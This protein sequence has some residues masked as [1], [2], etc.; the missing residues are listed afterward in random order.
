MMIKKNTGIPVREEGAKELSHFSTG[1]EGRF[2]VLPPPPFKDKIFRI[3][4]PFMPPSPVPPPP[5][6]LLCFV[7]VTAFDL[8]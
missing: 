2:K 8:I 1:V 3:F 5:T 6:P 7:V 4:F